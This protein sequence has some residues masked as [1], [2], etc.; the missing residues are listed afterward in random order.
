MGVDARTQKLRRPGC[1]E[2]KDLERWMRLATEV[3]QKKKKNLATEEASRGRR[4][5]YVRA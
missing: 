2:K 3:F 4:Q 5:T 1:G